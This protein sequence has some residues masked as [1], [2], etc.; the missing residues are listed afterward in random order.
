MVDSLRKG[1]FPLLVLELGDFLEVD[2]RKAPLVNPL[3]A[4]ILARDGVAA[5]TPGPPEFND[6]ARFQELM[7]GQGIAVVSTN[8]FIEEQGRR[9]AA[10]RSVVVDVEGLRVGLLGILG[11]E[12]HEKIRPPAGVGFVLQDPLEAI[13]EELP[14]LRERADLI[15]VMACTGDAEAERIAAEAPGVDVV[16]CGYESQSSSMAYRIGET[17]I[18]RGGSHGQYAGVTRLIVSPENEILDWGGRNIVLYPKLP[19]NPAVAARVRALKG[20]PPGSHPGLPA[21]EDCH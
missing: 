19:E 8:V 18:N 10:A 1:H 14:Q 21:Q 11:S 3:L 7:T 20:E 13:A 15:V 16:L 6:W 4:E 9:A 2:P 17:I 5:I 12:A